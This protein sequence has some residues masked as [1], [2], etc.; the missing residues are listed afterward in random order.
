MRNLVFTLIVFTSLFL[1]NIAEAQRHQSV[2]VLRMWD[3]SSFSVN[4]DNRHYDAPS[5]IFRLD[6]VR[7]G[8]HNVVVTQRYG[9]HGA[10]QLVF[11]GKVNIQNNSKVVARIT[12]HNRLEIVKVTPLGGNNNGYNNGN[13][14]YNNGNNGYNNGNNG[15]NN[16]NYNLPALNVPSLKRTLDN[17]AFD[18]DRRMIAEQALASHSYYSNQVTNILSMFSF[19]SSK[20]KLAKYAYGNCIDKENYYR[21]NSAFSF[22][23]SIRELNNYIGNYRPSYNN[24]RGNNHYNN[25]YN[26]PRY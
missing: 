10:S 12:R 2:F 5:S 21:V 9:R 8:M 11:R 6:K 15:Y 18:S 23:S 20:L 7:P 25:N 4:F 19:E 16:G 13:N 24:N 1:G 14:G 17:T 26:R 3:N 22:S